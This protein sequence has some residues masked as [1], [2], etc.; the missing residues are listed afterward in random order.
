MIH[1]AHKDNTGPKKQHRLYDCEDCDVCREIRSLPAKNEDVSDPVSQ[2][3]SELMPEETSL[4]TRKENS[5]GQDSG[6]EDS[7]PAV[8]FGEMIPLKFFVGWLVKHVPEKM[9]EDL[10]TTQCGSCGKTFRV[11]LLE[12]NIKCEDC[13]SQF[14]PLIKAILYLMKKNAA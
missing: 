1:L 6:E 4:F 5:P 2:L 7:G 14:E 11:F 3:I 8:F 13:D 10:L 9:R 12:G